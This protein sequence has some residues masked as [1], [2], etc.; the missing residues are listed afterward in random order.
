L[1]E[2]ILL[3]VKLRATEK[4]MAEIIG[5]RQTRIRNIL[6]ALNIDPRSLARHKPWKPTVKIPRQEWKLGYF[7]GLLDGEG[8][9]Y[10]KTEPYY[11]LLIRI[12][13]TN[14]E[15][16]DWL[17]D[18]FGG[19]I[20]QKR[21]KQKNWSEAWH[22]EITRI[23]DVKIILEAVRDYLIIKRQKAEELLKLIEKKYESYLELPTYTP[24]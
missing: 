13:N 11:A 5:C 16:I 8:G 17:V 3:L 6:K 10:H 2:K 18:N 20:V 4:E 23:E 9:I 14:K 21:T 7:A 19:R 1:K 22:W 12:T 15:V 24:S